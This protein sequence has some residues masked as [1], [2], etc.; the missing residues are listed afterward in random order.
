M[1]T[2]V[3]KATQ[4]KKQDLAARPLQFHPA[5][6]QLL[7]ISPVLW[8][9]GKRLNDGNDEPLGLLTLGLA[10]VLAWRDRRSLHASACV[11]TIGA[12]LVLLSVLGIHWLP[13]MIRAGLALTGIA[14]CYGIHRRAGLMGLLVLSLPLA[15]SM[16]FFLGYPLRVAAAEGAVRLLE[17]GSLVVSRSGTQIEL[18][19]QVIGVD[20]ACGGVRMLWHALAAAMA[21]AAIHRLTWRATMVGG[22]L[23]IALV[24]PANTVRAALLAVKESGRLPEML[25]GHGGI[26]LAGF[27]IVLVPLWFAISS[28]ARPAFPAAP[29]VAAGRAERWLLACAAVLA[30]L[31]AFATPRTPA[32]PDFAQGPQVFTFGGLTLPLHPLP[33]TDAERA[34][35]KSF[36]GTLASYQ[37]GNDQVIL[38]RVTEATRRLHPSR[39]CLRAAGFETT[40]AITVTLGD[41]S[42]W[43]R[44]SASRD[45]IRRIVHERITSGRDGSAWT[46]V[47]AWYWAALGHPLNGPWQAETVISKS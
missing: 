18:G 3:F 19:G 8:W 5:I 29:Q 27:A 4:L 39:D 10:L 16:Q 21:L 7:A 45:G 6:L 42:T 14:A 34:F 9:F 26:G 11:R 46:D 17:L 33:S 47:S 30:P 40:D 44:F 20:P 38:R 2:L 1:I 28:R 36:P 41:G 43:A 35:A 15:A 25:L 13:P 31:L 22:L 37:W 12:V 32:P 23:A 24:I